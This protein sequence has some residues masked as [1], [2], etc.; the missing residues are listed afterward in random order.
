MMEEN[1]KHQ[2][3]IDESSMLQVGATLQ[4]GKYLLKY[5]LFIL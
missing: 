4:D 1:E 3:R 2:H 5:Y